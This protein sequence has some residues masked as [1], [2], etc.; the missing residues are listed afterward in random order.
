ME[1]KPTQLRFRLEPSKD[2][3]STGSVTRGIYYQVQHGLLQVAT[4][5][6]KCCN[7]CEITGSL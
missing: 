2:I 1:N 3:D 6:T 7:Y 4:G 5:P